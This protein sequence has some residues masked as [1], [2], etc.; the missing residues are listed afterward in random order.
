MQRGV[1]LLSLFYLPGI[2]KLIQPFITGP[3]K[4]F[5]SIFFESLKIREKEGIQKGD[6]LDN[7][8]ALKNG[9]QNP[10]FSTSFSKYE[11]WSLY[12]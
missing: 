12:H 6:L 9:E 7:M 4:Y 11:T 5:R 10:N 3:A 1:V 8:I 2:A